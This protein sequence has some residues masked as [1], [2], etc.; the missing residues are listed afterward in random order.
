MT[1][2][3]P[4]QTVQASLVGGLLTAVFPGAPYYREII[5]VT[6]KS[7]ANA[8]VSIYTGAIAD[9]CLLSQ[10]TYGQVNA[11][12]PQTPPPVPAGTPIYV[13]WSLGSGNTASA[14]LQ[15]RGQLHIGGN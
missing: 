8:T 6:L 12:A 1:F 9:A 5:R 11:W 15:T 10:N 2:I 7:S 4:N 14:V 13:Q 3:P